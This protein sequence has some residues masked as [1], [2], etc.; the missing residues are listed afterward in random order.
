MVAVEPSAGMR[1]QRPATA[2]PALNATA[3]S[4]PFDD[5]AFDAATATVAVHQWRDVAR[6]LAELRRIGWCWPARVMGYLRRAWRQLQSSF[7]ARS[8]TPPPP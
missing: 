5:G 7:T 8:T 3:E 2:V 4:P 6:G 1:A